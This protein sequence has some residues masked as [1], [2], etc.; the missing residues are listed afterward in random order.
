MT[1]LGTLTRQ[2]LEHL[3]IERNYSRGTIENYARYLERFLAWSKLKNVSGITDD[4]IREYRIF[5]N[6]VEIEGKTLS[7]KTQNNYLIAL[8]QF[9]KYCA[10]RDIKTLSAEKVELGKQEMRHIEFLDE[11]ELYRLLGGP[12]AVFKKGNLS[13]EEQLLSRRDKAILET[14]FSTGLRVSELCNLNRDQVNLETREFTV[15]GK[16]R[17]IR[18]V[19]LSEPAVKSLKEYM[20]LRGD[21]NEALFIGSG[22]ERIVSRTVQRI[23]KKYATRAGISRKKVSPHQ[24]RHQLA[25]DLLRN[26]ADLRSVQE[27]LGHANVSTTQIYTH[28]TNPELKKIHEKFHDNK[29]K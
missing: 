2:F 6:R 11:D 24:L 27:I 25:T 12:E 15:R 28:F 19:F 26:G 10:K 5:L 29:R 3:E 23:V 16:G 20:A 18:M 13:K 14:L 8:R 21:I 4:T 7:K 1:E 22:S 17:K 9:L